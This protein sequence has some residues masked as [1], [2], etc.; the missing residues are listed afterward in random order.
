MINNGL[1]VFVDKDLEN[2][3]EVRGKAKTRA[4]I[5]RQVMG[6]TKILF[7]FVQ[8][9]IHL[10]AP[11]NKTETVLFGLPPPGTE[12]SE[13]LLIQPSPVSHKLKMYVTMDL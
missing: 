5:M 10:E 12:F 8:V 4:D 9:I 7:L 6:M 2:E 3:T 13:G 1:K 11:K